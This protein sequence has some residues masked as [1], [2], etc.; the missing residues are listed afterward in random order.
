MGLN[1]YQCA[2]GSNGC[3]DPFNKYGSGVSTTGTNNS[4]TYCQVRVLYHIVE[5]F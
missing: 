3:S 5:S 4:Y 2:A 1:C